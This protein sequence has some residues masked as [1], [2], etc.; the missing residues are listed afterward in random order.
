MDNFLFWEAIALAKHTKK[1][2][3]V[4]RLDFEKAYNR[5]CWDFLEFSV[6]GKLDFDTTIYIQGN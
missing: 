1:K 2:V 4:L 6:I 3:V 5:A